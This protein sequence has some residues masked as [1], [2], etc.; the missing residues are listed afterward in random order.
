MEN[1]Q[2][3]RVCPCKYRITRII[4]TSMDSKL[5]C[6]P[7]S[8]IL[9]SI[10][11]FLKLGLNTQ[12]IWY[13]CHQYSFWNCKSVLILCTFPGPR[14]LSE[15][16]AC[17]QLFI[18]YNQFMYKFQLKPIKLSHGATERKREKQF[19]ITYHRNAGLHSM[20]T[21]Y[22]FMFKLSYYQSNPGN[23]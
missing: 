4:R 6:I 15:V 13:Y 23:D 14:H 10:Q 16:T 5:H 20:K 18:V 21:E 9:L 2:Q 3:D 7:Y 22:L 11:W 1:K 19:C 12:S 17:G 8:R